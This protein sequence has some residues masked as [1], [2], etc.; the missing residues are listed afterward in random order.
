MSDVSSG[1]KLFHLPSPEHTWE[2]GGKWK[3]FAPVSAPCVSLLHLG[4]LIGRESTFHLA[5]PLSSF[6]DS[7]GLLCWLVLWLLWLPAPADA[8]IWVPV[9]QALLLSTVAV[10]RALFLRF[11]TGRICAVWPIWTRSITSRALCNKLISIVR[12]PLPPPSS[13]C[14]LTLQPCHGE[15]QRDTLCSFQRGI[16]CGLSLVGT[17]WAEMEKQGLSALLI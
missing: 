3:P 10:S 9:G 13:C 16:A 11:P 6:V 15:Y 7:F 5:L 17:T 4:A 12:P 1:T 8:L 14:S 2:G